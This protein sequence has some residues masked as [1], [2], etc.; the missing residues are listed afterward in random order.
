[1]GQ[2]EGDFEKGATDGTEDALRVITI[3][4]STNLEN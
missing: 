2:T 3:A 4:A 1:M